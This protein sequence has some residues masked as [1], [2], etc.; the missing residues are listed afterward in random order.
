MGRWNPYFFIL[1][2]LNPFVTASQLHKFLGAY[3]AAYDRFFHD[4]LL[5]QL[6]VFR[7]STT[8]AAPAPTDISLLNLGFNTIEILAAVNG[9]NGTYADNSTSTFQIY[10]TDIL[11]TDPSPSAECATA[12]TAI[13]SCNSTVPLMRCVLITK[14]TRLVRFTHGNESSYPFLVLGDLVYV[15]TDNCTASLADYRSNVVSSCGSYLVPG[16]YNVSY[17]PTLAV[18]TIAGAY[19][20]QCLQDPTTQQF[21]QPLITSYNASGGLLDLPEDE[22]CTFCTL[23]TLNVTLSNPATY[24]EPIAELLS[25]AITICGP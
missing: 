11:P 3:S 1:F 20:E 2:C 16:P 23:K 10:T 12:L 17:S 15:C 24:S 22:L 9:T 4:G 14:M 13:I 25:S 18:D 8:T 21:C 5:K 7:Q 19:V 6:N